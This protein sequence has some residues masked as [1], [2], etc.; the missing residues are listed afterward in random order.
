MQNQKAIDS[1]IEIASQPGYKDLF[2][3]FLPLAMQAISQSF[4]Y[5]LVAIVAVRGK[6]GPLN[7]AAMAQANLLLFFLLSSCAG[8]ITA[9]MVYSVNRAGLIRFRSLNRYFTLGIFLVH[10]LFCLPFFAQIILSSIMGLSGDLYESTYFAFLLSLPLSL[11]FNFR[12]TAMVVLFNKKLTG[13]AFSATVLRIIFTIILSIAMTFLGY[14]GIFW[15]TVCQIIP[16]LLEAEL[17]N[18]LARP[19]ILELMKKEGPSHSIFE[20]ISLTMSFSI[21]R[22]MMAFSGYVVA[23]FAARAPEPDI[24]LPAYYAALGLMNPMAFAASRIQAMV[25]S[26]AVPGIKNFRLFNFS[27]LAGVICGITPLL[28]T[29]PFISE[30]YYGTLQKIPPENL[31]LVRYSAF[32]LVLTPFTS[33]LRSYVE[34]WAA[35]GRKPV[36]LMAGQGV[37]L[38]FVVSAAFFAFNLGVQGNAIGPFAIF[39]G[40]ICAALVL[41]IAL[42]MKDSKE[43]EEVQNTFI[44]P[45]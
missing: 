14:T 11:I 29:L 40:N 32:I 5:P 15:A 35:R 45:A 18:R 24:M 39:I 10:A 43:T 13:L 31:A 1:D 42:K 19:H 34:G 37:Y 16:L 7:I 25:I 2:K 38:G 23:G 3:Y 44:N 21:G 20:M 26:F 6:E 22:M 8:L 33:A 28:F 41:S 27:V 12:N 9:G 36:A 17:I 30:W 4:T